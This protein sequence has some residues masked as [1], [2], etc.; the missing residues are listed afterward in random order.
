ML[1]LPLMMLEM[2]PR[3]LNSTFVTWLL[4]PVIEVYDTIS[5]PVIY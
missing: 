1:K 4:L 3:L 5:V 2:F